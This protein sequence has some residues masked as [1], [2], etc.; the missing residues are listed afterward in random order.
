MDSP[1]PDSERRP[2]L[3]ETRKPR[4]RRRVLSRGTLPRRRRSARGGRVRGPAGVR[5]TR[6]PAHRT[7]RGLTGPPCPRPPPRAGGG[8]RRRA[9]GVG[10]GVHADEGAGGGAA[11]RPAGG[12]PG[13]AA[14]RQAHGLQRPVRPQGQGG[15]GPDA[16]AV[17][18]HQAQRVRPNPSPPCPRSAAEWKGPRADGEAGRRAGFRRGTSTRCRRRRW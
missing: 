3:T 1:N 5:R 14:V 13:G 15:G 4:R 2:S 18:L 16:Q 12:E 9:D 17:L 7:G 11:A 8:P 10:D 6:A